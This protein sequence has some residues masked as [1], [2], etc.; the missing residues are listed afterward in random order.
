MTD[1]QVTTG[2]RIVWIL[3]VIVFFIKLILAIISLIAFPIG[4]ILGICDIVIF[5]F[6]LVAMFN[7]EVKAKMGM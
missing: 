4:T 7:P 5:G 1:G 6:M 2:D 3:L